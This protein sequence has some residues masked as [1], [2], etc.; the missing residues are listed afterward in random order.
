MIFNQRGDTL[1]PNAPL[2]TNDWLLKYN[3]DSRAHTI[4]CY[5]NANHS[6]W[7]CV[8]VCVCSGSSSSTHKPTLHS[9]A[10]LIASLTGER[11]SSAHYYCRPLS[12]YLRRLS[13]LT[14]G[15][16]PLKLV[17][18]AQ[19][20]FII[21]PLPI[22]PGPL[23]QPCEWKIAR[24]TSLCSAP[25]HRAIYPCLVCLRRASLSTG[26]HFLFILHF[27]EGFKFLSR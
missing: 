5:H 27:S 14:S 11:I 3:R 10:E 8:C 23:Q 26:L 1:H 13:I 16:S 17:V 21:K 20:G 24:S 4:S 2:P 12:V 7:M 25:V 22:C 18:S 9:T 15:S 19:C 6:W